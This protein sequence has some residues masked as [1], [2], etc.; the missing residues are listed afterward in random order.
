MSASLV[1]MEVL[2]LLRKKRGECPCH[3]SM[4][5]P[6]QGKHL[7]DQHHY[8]L[9]LSNVLPSLD[10]ESDANG[11]MWVKPPNWSPNGNGI[12]GFGRFLRT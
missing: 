9:P 8:K 10:L 5:D 12:V 6:R 3:G 1:S 11:N 7:L 4:Y 2:A